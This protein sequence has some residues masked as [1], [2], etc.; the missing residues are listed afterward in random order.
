MSRSGLVAPTTIVDAPT[1]RAIARMIALERVAHAHGDRAR[2]PETGEA[3]L[4]GRDDVEDRHVGV[5]RGGLRQTG[6][7]RVPPAR[8]VVD[9]DEEVDAGRSAV[10]ALLVCPHGVR[11]RVHPVLSARAVP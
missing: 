2:Q 9:G 6:A 5:L 7:Q 11:C 1:R 3:P 4:A 10:P 8:G